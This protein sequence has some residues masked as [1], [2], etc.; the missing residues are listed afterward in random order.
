M[1]KEILINYIQRDKGLNDK[2][3]IST[4]TMSFIPTVEAKHY[5]MIYAPLPQ[6]IGLNIVSCSLSCPCSL[7]TVTFLHSCTIKQ[8]LYV[9]NTVKR[10]ML[11]TQKHAVY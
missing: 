6:K 8:K 4:H 5:A 3:N 11:A 1:G 10:F 9:F 7:K 2:F